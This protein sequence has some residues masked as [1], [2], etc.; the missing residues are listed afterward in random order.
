MRNFSFWYL[1]TGIWLIT[2]WRLFFRR[3]QAR[4]RNHLNYKDPL[5]FTPNHSNAFLDPICTEYP[6][7]PYKQ[8]HFMVRAD[9][10]NNPVAAFILNSWKLIPAYRMR[11]GVENLSK[12]DEIFARVQAMMKRHDGIIIFTE[13][14]HAIPRRMRQVKKGLSR[15]VFGM[16]ER[17]GADYQMAVK[18][19]P[20]GLVYTEPHYFGGDLFVNYGKPI[21]VADYMNLYKEHPAKAM[22]KLTQDVHEAIKLVMI[23]IEN[24]ECYEAIEIAMHVY[25]NNFRKQTTKPAQRFD[26]DKKLIVHLELLLK[27]KPEMAGEFNETTSKYKL[28]IDK[29]N[30]RDWLFTHK[31]FS[32]SRICLWWTLL[33]LMFPL[34]LPGL[35]VHAWPLMVGNKIAFSKIKDP[36]FYSSIIMSV[37]VLLISLQYYIALAL[38]I[39][40]A[41]WWAAVS[42]VPVL[43]LNGMLALWW[44]RKSAKLLGMM[45]YNRFTKKQEALYSELREL[46]NKIVGWCNF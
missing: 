39:I 36:A 17:Y 23:H 40:M 29:H 8:L 9:V 30:L 7:F 10:F 42:I 31:S 41:P 38:M 28:T 3:Y 2:G 22:N 14:N 19:V 24:E 46:R 25:A 27:Q 43:L 4:G 5:I 33:V 15:I 21:A 13:A 11:D 26:F 37:F 45:R 34:I 20:T 18:I 35:L 1:L 6:V 16:N 32:K 44:G 12:N